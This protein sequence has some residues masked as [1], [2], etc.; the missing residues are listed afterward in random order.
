MEALAR[1]ITRAGTREPKSSRVNK[2]DK[3]IT[4]LPAGTEII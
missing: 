4:K 2:V 3:Y 1:L